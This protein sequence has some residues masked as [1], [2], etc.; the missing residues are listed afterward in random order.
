MLFESVIPAVEFGCDDIF[1]N[2]LIK[3]KIIEY[4]KVQ[5]LMHDLEKWKNIE[6]L[7]EDAGKEI[8]L[9]LKRF[10]DIFINNKDGIVP[11]EEILSFFSPKEYTFVSHAYDVLKCGV[12][13]PWNKSDFLRFIKDNVLYIRGCD[14]LG[15]CDIDDTVKTMC[16]IEILIWS[17]YNTIY[18]LE[19]VQKE[20]DISYGSLM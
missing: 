8:S 20:F 19:K 2:G 11:R 16:L 7:E 5:S 4:V 17:Y 14:I 13:G 1:G 9:N 15:L 6:E 3:D 18:T 12:S 10:Y